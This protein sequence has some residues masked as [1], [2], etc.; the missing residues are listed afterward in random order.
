MKNFNRHSSNDLIS[1][2]KTINIKTNI[3]ADK[4]RNL[5]QKNF[6]KKVSLLKK[7]DFAKQNASSLCTKN[8]NLKNHSEKEIK[9][10]EESN[11]PVMN[12]QKIK[13]QII[14]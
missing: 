12:L 4:N 1:G 3:N 6:N 7:Y 9:R 11:T 13:N 8:D 14:L 5:S 2:E 10:G